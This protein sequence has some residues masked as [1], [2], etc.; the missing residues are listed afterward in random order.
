MTD[1]EI[2]SLL[3]ALPDAGGFVPKPRDH[4]AKGRPD[5]AAAQAAGTD[6]KALDAWVLAHGGQMRSGRGPGAGGV[7]PGRRVAPPP[8]APQR[9]Y[10][11][12]SAT[13]SD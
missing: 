3:A 2:R 11:M 10:V 5:A 8:S 6:L 13:L 9:Y 12:P 1:D 7:R 4:V